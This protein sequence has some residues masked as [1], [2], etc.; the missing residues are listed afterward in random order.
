[1]S[2]IP[3]QVEELGVDLLSLAGHKL[4]AAK[5]VGALYIREGLRLPNL[6]HGASVDA[7]VARLH[8]AA[9]L[10][11]GL[12]HPLNVVGALSRVLVG[13][14]AGNSVCHQEDGDLDVAVFS[15]ERH[16]RP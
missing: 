15:L 11:H 6:L 1:M 14:G 4:Y 2:K 3:T 8:L 9:L 5:G 16:R 7:R 13:Q 12:H 10:E